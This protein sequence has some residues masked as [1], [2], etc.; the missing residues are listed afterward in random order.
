MSVVALPTR[1]ALAV[2][3]ALTL[4]VLLAGLVVAPELAVAQGE[5]PLEEGARNALSTA[6]IVLGAGFTILLGFVAIRLFA[7]RNFGGLA[8]TLLVGGI[9]AWVVF[10]PTGAGETLQSVGDSLLGS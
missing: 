10:N 4:L 7:Q 2:A 3:A 8:V 1:R 5:N 9:V 6:Q